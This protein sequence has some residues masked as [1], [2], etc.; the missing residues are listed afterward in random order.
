MS[1]KKKAEV[2]CPHCGQKIIV[3]RTR[4][5]RI[6][7]TTV[8]GLTLAGVGGVIGAGIGIATAGTAVAATIPLAAIGLVVGLGAGYLVGDKAVDKHKCP[9]C[10]KRINLV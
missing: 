10:K 1:K 6:L 9:K 4:G 3:I 5:G 8:L 2:I 7:I